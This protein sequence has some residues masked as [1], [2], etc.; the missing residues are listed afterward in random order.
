MKKL[1]LLF[2]ILIVS[3]SLQSQNISNPYAS[4]G[5]KKPKV[6]TATNG[7][8]NEFY[9]KDSLVLI[10][11]NAISRKTGEIVYSKKNNQNIIVELIKQEEEKFRF[12][13]SD[14]LAR[15]F[16][17]NSPYAYAEND[18]I[19]CIDLDGLEKWVNVENGKL[20]FG[21]FNPTTIDAEKLIP[22]QQ[23]LAMSIKSELLINQAVQNI[24]ASKTFRDVIE[25]SDPIRNVVVNENYDGLTG[26]QTIYDDAGT[27]SYNVQISVSN[28]DSYNLTNRLTWELTN[29][30]NSKNG[31]FSSNESAVTLSGIS[32]EAFVRGVIAIEAEA[33]FNTIMVSREKGE[34]QVLPG[35]LEEKYGSMSPTELQNNKESFMKD[36][37]AY[38]YDFG[39]V[40]DG[41]GTSIREAYGAQY[42]ELKND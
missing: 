38:Q 21:P 24:D 7:A 2:A 26:T 20:R 9:T 23:A 28:G 19:R 40:E 4:I 25:Q 1:I 22:L 14:P 6:A 39:T 35:N 37:A 5:K 29:V 10:N 12:L 11:N 30:I 42:D 33:E 13:S 16:A 36:Y 8:Y 15:H 3:F 41:K 31:N 34:M 17:W 32:K 27:E 18:V